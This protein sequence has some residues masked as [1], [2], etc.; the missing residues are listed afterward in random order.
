MEPWQLHSFL[1]IQVITG[2]LS[3]ILAFLIY[4]RNSEYKGNIYLSL[5][6]SMYSLYP[7]GRFFYELGFSELVVQIS[8]RVSLIGTIL[9]MGAFLIS[10]SIFCLG[11]YAKELKKYKIAGG[12]VTT[13][14]CI[15][16][17]LPSSITFEQLDPTTTVWSK[18]LMG[19]FSAYILLTT[20]RMIY[21]LT[22]T[23]NE[24]KVKSPEIS[25]KLKTF[26]LAL[27]FSLG[28]VLF[29]IIENITQIHFL[30]IF[31]YLF[32]LLFIIFFSY[33]LMKKKND[34][35]IE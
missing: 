25:N 6:F 26:R 28:I 3:I 23:I 18:I 32:L 2:I 34:P 14:V 35:K 22:N 7:F 4:K 19:V 24:L 10:I 13:L 29:S 21:L 9:G 20:T 11:S 30:N 27:L 5:A 17:I 31:T 16:I 15:V 12:I 1:V 8:L 33:P